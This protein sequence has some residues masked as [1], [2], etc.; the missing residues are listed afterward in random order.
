MSVTKLW[1]MKQFVSDIFSWTLLEQINTAMSIVIFTRL[2]V[3]RL[4]CELLFLLKQNVI[5]KM[6]TLT[7][8]VMSYK[9]TLSHASNLLIC[10]LYVNYLSAELKKS[11]AKIKVSPLVI[12]IITNNFGVLLFYFYKFI[13][14]LFQG[15][16]ERRRI[17]TRTKFKT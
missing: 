16:K 2:H 3:Q 10:I 5:G 15:E 11:F 6:L 14:I 1:K 8:S 17:K 7:E 13:L 12:T 4:F 9:L